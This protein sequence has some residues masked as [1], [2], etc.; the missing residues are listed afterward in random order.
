MQR[1]PLMSAYLRR[2]ADG[3]ITVASPV[4]QDVLRVFKRFKDVR[5]QTLRTNT[6]VERLDERVVRRFSWPTK[7][8]NH[9]LTAGPRI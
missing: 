8:K 6:C 9:L 2:C 1:T 5:I 3:F 4:C 7:V